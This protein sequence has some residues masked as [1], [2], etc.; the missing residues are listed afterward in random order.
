M[1]LPLT[2]FLLTCLEQ[3]NCDHDQR[4]GPYLVW[5]GF[6]LFYTQKVHIIANWL[7]WKRKTA[8]VREQLPWKHIL[9]GKLE[10][11]LKVCILLQ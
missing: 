10:K 1:I 7:T 2:K 3:S 11:L 6:S 9:S 5:A 8:A 4:L